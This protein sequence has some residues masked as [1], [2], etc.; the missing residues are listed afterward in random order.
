MGAASTIGLDLAKSLFQVHRID[1]TRAVLMKQ[2]SRA[3]V[4]EYFCQQPRCLVGIEA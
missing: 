1:V 2:V 3:K 4:L